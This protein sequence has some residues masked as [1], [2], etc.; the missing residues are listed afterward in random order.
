MS[1]KP[2]LVL[3]WAPVVL[4]CL[5]LPLAAA[6]PAG[7]TGILQWRNGDQLAGTLVDA[8]STHL[9]W[10]SPSFEEA[11]ELGLEHLRSVGFERPEVER[12]TEEPWRFVLHGGDMIYGRL[13]DVKQEH[14]VLESDR[15]GLVQL[16][17]DALYSIERLDDAEL[18]VF[19]PTETEWRTL[20]RSRQTSEWARTE[21]D[22][23]ATTLV[24]AEL[25]RDL[26]TA[27]ITQVE[28]GL[29]WTKEAAFLVTFVAPNGR[30]V[31]KDTVKLETWGDRLVLQTLA[32]NGDFKQVMAL[33]QRPDNLRLR[34]IWNRFAGELSVYSEYGRLLA[35]LASDSPAVENYTALYI[36]NKG[37][38]LTL[39]HLHVKQNAVAPTQG[40]SKRDYV[41]LSSGDSHVGRL[42]DYNPEDEFLL[43]KAQDGTERTISISEIVGVRFANDD[44]TEDAP[45]RFRVTYS[46]GAMLHG[47]L[48]KISGDTAFLLTPYSAEP[49]QANLADATELQFSSKTPIPTPR[50]THVLE[51]GGLKLHGTLSMKEDEGVLGWLPTGSTNASALVTSQPMR[52]SREAASDAV[53]SL[54]DNMDVLYLRSGDSLPC[55]LRSIDTDNIRVATE[56]AEDV[57]VSVAAIKAIELHNASP[58][59][60]GFNDPGWEYPDEEGALRHDET[61]V[62]FM[63]T[64]QIRH[65]NLLQSRHIEF[66]L[67][68]SP[69]VHSQLTLRLG[70][71]P[72]ARPSSTPLVLYCSQQN[73]YVSQGGQAR[74]THANTNRQCEAHISLD[75]LRDEISLKVDGRTV[76]TEKMPQP[77]ESRSVTLDYRNVGPARAARL[78]NRFEVLSQLTI[79]DLKTARSGGRARVHINEEEKEIALT[80][81][82]HRKEDPPT[83]ILVASNG[84]L[85]R[86][87]L[88]RLTEEAAEITSRGVQYTLPRK[89]IA[90]IV[91]LDESEEEQ[92]QEEPDA[93]AG[94]QA[95]SNVVLL[96]LENG[97]A[98]SLIPETVENGNLMGRHPIFGSWQV[99]M[100]QI[101]ELRTGDQISR[102]QE[103]AY[104][105][106]R[107]RPA[108]E[109]QFATVDPGQGTAFGTSSPLVGTPADDFKV[110]LVGGESFQLSEQKGK[111][112]VIDF[113]A[114]WCGPC[115]KAMPELMSAVENFSPDQVVLLAVNHQESVP[116][117]NQFLITRD[118]D[119]DAALD[120]DGAL[121]RQFLVE[122]L[123]HTV[124]IAPDGTI[125]R[126][127]VGAHADLK[128]ELTKVLEELVKTDND[129]EGHEEH[130][131]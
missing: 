29:H 16:R 90:A 3:C 42:Q 92:A 40:S 48:D 122:A 99:P 55:R 105:D 43:L 9:R 81:P 51:V 27:A 24:G 21:G 6:E 121:A 108:I 131:E 5:A 38:D 64:A 57:S 116:I 80:I 88:I 126:V 97:T 47:N 87:R 67:A 70:D 15:H 96:A 37:A 86:G 50:V 118:W 72:N 54:P 68:W 23:L 91:W 123:P 94:E 113:W 1:A 78:A 8:T 14:L 30:E 58:S 85:L 112:V 18:I 98:F 35:T 56:F 117:V 33:N 44:R 65:P 71:G 62:Q 46:D 120:R 89:R 79:S 60:A 45:S 101:R 10:K 49:I 82:R 69:S 111:V 53:A 109:P 2:I 115:I 25:M 59:I 28:I 95:A 114:S 39:A 31:P 129:H 110:Q 36:E 102:S 93:E 124:V 20:H 128:T 41:L 106:W 11:F 77:L 32:R 19:R 84:D 103:M 125:A 34:L 52:V 119:L 74:F 76:L 130:E 17:R 100:E 127:H 7:G 66:D 63:E 73:L 22:E 4:T 75:V 61:S 13:L 104:A 26:G 83:H 107:A 12:V